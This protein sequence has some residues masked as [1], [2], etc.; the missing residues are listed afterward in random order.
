MNEIIIAI[1]AAIAPVT[2]AIVGALQSRSSKRASAR[3]SIE[4]W[5]MHDQ[6]NWLLKKQLPRHF[7]RVVEEFEL[8]HAKGGNS[9]VDGEVEEYKAWVNSL[10]KSLNKKGAKNAQK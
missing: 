2:T 3:Q 8:Y 7:E 9:V 1:I 4:L 5:I 6:L 10:S